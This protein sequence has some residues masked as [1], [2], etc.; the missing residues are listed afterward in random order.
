M[1]CALYYKLLME[2]RR[3]KFNYVVVCGAAAALSSASP[4]PVCP[5]LP[6][7]FRINDT[8]RCNW[9]VFIISSGL[10]WWG[11]SG[12]FN[13]SPLSCERSGMLFMPS[14]CG[15]KQNGY[16]A[17]YLYVFFIIISLFGEQKGVFV[18]FLY[19]R[20][21]PTKFGLFKVFFVLCVCVV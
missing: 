16:V 20:F 11:V 2:S 10:R 1:K 14:R 15:L 13:N 8:T 9:T 19:P 5:T 6:F 3:A 18:N 17:F 4:R 21:Y 12:L 7:S